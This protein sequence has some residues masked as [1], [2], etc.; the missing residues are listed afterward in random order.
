M[1]L[2]KVTVVADEDT[3]L[4]PVSPASEAVTTQVPALVALRTPAEMAQPE[5]VPFATLKL[6][7]PAPE[8]PLVVR[9]RPE[10]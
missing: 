10:P 7:A 6:N 1:A 4:Y 3:A 9:V 5:A 8:P 2:A